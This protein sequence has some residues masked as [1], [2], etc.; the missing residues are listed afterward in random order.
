MI[1][2]WKIQKTAS[3]KIFTFVML[4]IQLNAYRTLN[5]LYFL[6][7]SFHRLLLA[8]NGFTFGHSLLNERR[9]LKKYVTKAIFFIFFALLL[10]PLR[11]NR[12][13]LKYCIYSICS[14]KCLAHE[15][16]WLITICE[17]C[18]VPMHNM[19]AHVN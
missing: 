10:L 8:H 7:C 16:I 5:N 18:L 6:F 2:C 3:W 11:S 14:N 4:M 15:Y 19:H 9:H 13:N 12:L 1:L 17:D